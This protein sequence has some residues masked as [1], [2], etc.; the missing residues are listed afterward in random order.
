MTVPKDNRRTSR[1]E[2]IETTEL[3]AVVEG[4]KSKDIGSKRP[5][6]IVRGRK[7]MGQWQID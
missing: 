1:G 4:R 6:R 7:S 2:S 5:E 3:E